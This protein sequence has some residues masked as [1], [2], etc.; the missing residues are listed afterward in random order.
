MLVRDDMTAEAELD[1]LGAP[2]APKRKRGKPELL[3]QRAV[4]RFAKE[5]VRGGWAFHVDS[6]TG[7][8]RGNA[9]HHKLARARAGV[10][11]GVPDLFVCWPGGGSCWLEVKAPDGKPTDQQLHIHSVLRACDQ[12][13]AVV[14]SVA[15]A[16]AA[17]RSFGAPVVGRT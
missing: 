3:V 13:V 8:S 4:I 12:Y 7:G 16:E 14:S 9:S 5:C 17:L 15:E 11:S 6:G 2:A 1:W 10:V